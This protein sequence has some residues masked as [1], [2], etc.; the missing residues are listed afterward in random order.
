MIIALHR[1]LLLIGQIHFSLK[2]QL[3]QTS[4]AFLYVLAKLKH[5]T[6]NN[7]PHYVNHSHV[8]PV[9]FFLRQ[10]GFLL[11]NAVHSPLL[12]QKLH[13]H[14]NLYFRTFHPSRTNNNIGPRTVATQNLSQF[15]LT[16]TASSLC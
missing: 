16:L 11:E 15:Q 5:V 1:L 6:I 2:M 10:M 4:Q 13:A 12:F 14:L 3:D 8:S 7:L 9:R